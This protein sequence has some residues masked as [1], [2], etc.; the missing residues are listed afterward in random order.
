MADASTLGL[1]CC[2]CVGVTRLGLG[3]GFGVGSPGESVGGGRAVTGPRWTEEAR[4]RESYERREL[5]RTRKS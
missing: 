5:A 3:G 4:R 2:R 1:E